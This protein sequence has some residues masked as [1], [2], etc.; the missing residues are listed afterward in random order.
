MRNDELGDI[1][2]LDKDIEHIFP[3]IIE[4]KKQER[5]KMKYLFG[6]SRLNKS[7]PFYSYINQVKKDVE[8]YNKD[9]SKNKKFGMVVFSKN[10][11]DNY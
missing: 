4:C 8:K 9:N 5:I 3:F 2:I 6:Y 1:E 7:N 10:Y 11:E